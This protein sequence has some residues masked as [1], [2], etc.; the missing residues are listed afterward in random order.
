MTKP[1][2]NTLFVCFSEQDEE[3]NRSMRFAAD[4]DVLDCEP[5]TSQERFD[6]PVV[7]RHFYDGNGGPDE[8]SEHTRRVEG[9][10]RMSGAARISYWDALN[11]VRRTTENDGE[12]SL[13]R[14]GHRLRALDLAYQKKLAGE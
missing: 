6:A 11:E 4:P 7:Y 8:V 9:S 13:Y 10:C 1:A 2:E 5:P 3:G 12:S 14:D